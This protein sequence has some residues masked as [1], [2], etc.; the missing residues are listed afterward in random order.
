MR[1]AFRVDVSVQV[2]IGHLMRCLT[3]A[4]T[5]KQRGASVR[6]ASR[7]MPGPWQVAL[8]E[9]GHEV[10]LLSGSSAKGVPDELAHSDWLGTSQ[11]IDAEQ[12]RQALGDQE[13]D[14]L[15]VDHYA[16]D[17]RWESALR[18]SATHV[19]VIDDLADRVHECDVLLD[20][21]F[22]ADMNTRY[23]GKVPAH[24]QPLLGPRYALLREEFYRERQ[25]IKPRTG[26]TRRVLICFGGVDADNHTAMAIEA[27]AG[28]Y[29]HDLAVDV[30]IGAQH[31]RRAQIETACRTHGFVCHVQTNEMAK[32]MAAADLAIGAG[33]STSWE[34]C[35]LGLPTVTFA[36]AENQ[37]RLVEDG[38]LHG[39]LYAPTLRG[40]S[41][42]S[43]R[44]HLETLLD[45]PLLL[46]MISRK[47]FDTVDGRGVQRV[48]RVMD[49]G[50]V[51]VRMATSADSR[52]LF[53]WRNH[54]SIRSVS[55][56]SEPIEWADH[57]AWFNTVLA[58]P[59]R[60]LLIG[61]RDGTPVG[62]VRFDVRD[63]EAEVS[64]YLAPEHL[65][66]GI[67]AELL[68]AAESWL[69]KE[70]MEVVSIRAEVLGDNQPSHRLFRAAGYTASA[71]R[72]TK[73][74]RFHG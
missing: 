19:L 61:E 15:V 71:S 45:N 49:C 25:R 9:K 21:N 34:R 46:Q 36:L 51:A 52:M 39:F 69:A 64:I 70:R 8:R 54:A 74:A 56:N 50:S 47:A 10:A 32:L 11:V 43:L 41:A 1:V 31:P 59:S 14:W 4:D 3:L 7:S 73:R 60:S 35:C 26:P 5:L 67:G 16:L 57:S 2:G 29:E 24:C 18:E 37:R 12:T 13:W 30:V 20:Q 63:G 6:F 65:A 28:L 53:S 42:L 44:S 62:S 22:Y 33:G 48:L 38:A 66:S 58:D 23:A 55:R 68:F 17:R 72:Y 40:M 27:V